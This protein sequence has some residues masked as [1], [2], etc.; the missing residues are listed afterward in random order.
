MTIKEHFLFYARMKSDESKLDITEEVDRFVSNLNTV[1]C[2]YRIKAN[3][4]SSFFT[5]KLSSFVLT[6]CTRLILKL[7]KPVSKEK[8]TLEICSEDLPVYEK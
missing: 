5:L 1:N 3:V 8:K 2:H 7:F 6:T 4:A